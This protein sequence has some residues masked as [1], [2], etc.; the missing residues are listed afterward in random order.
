MLKKKLRNYLTNGVLAVLVILLLLVV[1]EAKYETGMLPY[2]SSKTRSMTNANQ[3]D[4][5]YFLR[6]LAESGNLNPHRGL[7]DVLLDSRKILLTSDINANSTKQVV[8]SLLALNESDGVTPI[9]LYIRTTGGYHDLNDVFAIID[10]M[11]TIAAPVNTYAMGGCHYS[12]VMILSSGT[13]VRTAYQEA[14][15][16]LQNDISVDNKID[17]QKTQE[18]MRT[19]SFW[20]HFKQIPKYWFESLGNEKHFITAQDALDFGL[21]DEIAQP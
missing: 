4:T 16:M 9:D 21:I 19:R 18:S 15:L 20:M 6:L 10:V 3:Y 12:G 17:S 1:F 14:L 5:T 2:Q 11:R 8:G 13:G 7:D